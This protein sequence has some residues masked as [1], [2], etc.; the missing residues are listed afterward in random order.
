[1]RSNRTPRISNR[2]KL[3]E[4]VL[5]V[6]ISFL[7]LSTKVNLMRFVVIFKKLRTLSNKLKI[8]NA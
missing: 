3:I 6:E 8:Y 5:R 1:V 4:A 2:A 7:T